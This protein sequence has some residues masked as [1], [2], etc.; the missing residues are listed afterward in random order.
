MVS[1]I[2]NWESTAHKQCQYIKLCWGVLSSQRRFEIQLPLRF[3]PVGTVDHWV[4]WLSLLHPMLHFDVACNTL[5]QADLLTKTRGEQW[6]FF[7]S[8]V[9][10]IFCFG[11]ST[12]TINWFSASRPLL[13]MG[14][15]WFFDGFG[16]IQPSPFNDFQ[17]PD[18]CFQWFFDGFQIWDTNGQWW[19]W[20]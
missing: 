2:S 13:S 11:Y 5:W 4:W 3:Q 6:S 19:F 1:S 14:F 8:D 9:M 10:V 7:E 18:H 16:V 12:I 20:K 15:R 17:P